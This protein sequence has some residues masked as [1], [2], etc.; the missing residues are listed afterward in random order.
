MAGQSEH[1]QNPYCPVPGCRALRP[2]TDSKIVR[3][4]V[5]AFTDPVQLTAWVKASIFEL[6]NSVRDDVDKG[7]FFAYITRWRQPEELYYRTLYILF[8]ARETELPHIFSGARPN[9]FAA[10]WRKVNEVVFEGR[11]I[12]EKPQRGSSGEP[13]TAL[14]VVNTAAHASFA[15]IMTCVGFA[16]H[17]EY[18]DVIPKH[19]DHW[20]RLCIHLNYMEDM[21]KAGKAKEHVLAGV[22]NLHK[23][24]S[25]WQQ[26]PS[27]Q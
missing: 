21:F 4:L 13:F 15:A 17:K 3:E 24:A 12:L 6:S 18:Q 16:R 19:L 20:T 11:G 8:V 27:G 2:H 14:S 5:R 7:R 10:M 22:R 1:E 23:P 9:S 25:A 26:G